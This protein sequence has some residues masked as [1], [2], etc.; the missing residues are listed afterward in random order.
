MPLP[1]YGCR[2][3]AIPLKKFTGIH[4]I[5]PGIEKKRDGDEKKENIT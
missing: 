1:S 4:L 2:G 3:P 5:R